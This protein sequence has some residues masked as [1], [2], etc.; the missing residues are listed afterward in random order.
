M[1]FPDPFRMH[2]KHSLGHGVTLHIL[3]WF[4]AQQKRSRPR[5][6]RRK[7]LD[8][9]GVP[10]EPNRPKNLS[11]GAAAALEYEDDGEF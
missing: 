2:R 6:G 8:D 9:G 1:P 4:N 7:D 10:V 5:R 11:G 3:A